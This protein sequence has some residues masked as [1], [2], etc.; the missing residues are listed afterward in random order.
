M[1]LDCGV[2]RDPRH[3]L[4]NRRVYVPESTEVLTFE[5]LH[6]IVK[7]DMQWTQNKDNKEMQ[8]EIEKKLKEMLEEA[9][10]S[11]PAP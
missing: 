1:L 11:L 2:Q 6:T 3:F 4:H 8:D 7:T 5:G 9:V 10:N